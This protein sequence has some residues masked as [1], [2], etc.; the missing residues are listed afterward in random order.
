MEEI[1]EK[2]D[3]LKENYGLKKRH[4]SILRALK[5]KDMVAEEIA[6]KTNIPK[7]R[8]YDF[9]NELVHLGLIV[10]TSPNPAVFSIKNFETCIQ[11]FLK[12]K[13]SKE[14]E[15]NIEVYE[16]LEEKQDASKVSYFAGSES[17]I[18]ETLK[19][20]KEAESVRV[21]CMKERPPYLLYPSKKEDFKLARE[22]IS[23]KRNT[24]TGKGESAYSLYNGYFN[25]IKSGKPM[26]FLIDK[27]S[28][29]KHFERLELMG[30]EK[31]KKFLN[32]LKNNLKTLSFKIFII[33]DPYYI[34]ILSSDK[35]SVINIASE[36][37]SIGF[38]IESY[39]LSKIYKGLCE[40]Y[41]DSGI[42]IEK[43]LKDAN[44]W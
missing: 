39:G 21:I 23:Q 20:F 8:I 11:N 32:E 43:Y 16:L 41:Q 44:L 4:I 2:L 10:K 15:K 37:A 5:S 6:E 36:R 42:P 9:I 31:F 14:I 17:Y 25:F 40:D 38:V 7:G 1:I 27:I 28:M 18:E 19:F 24:Y 29:D 3:K 34:N 13:F 30:K 35:K 33:E 12:K 26:V 22:I